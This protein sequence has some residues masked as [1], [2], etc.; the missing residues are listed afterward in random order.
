MASWMRTWL[1]ATWF[2]KSQYASP[3]PKRLSWILL[4]FIHLLL[5]IST[6]T[7]LFYHQLLASLPSCCTKAYIYPIFRHIPNIFYKYV[8]ISL[9]IYWLR[10]I[11]NYFYVLLIK[12]GTFEVTSQY[13]AY[14]ISISSIVFENDK[15]IGLF[16]GCFGHFNMSHH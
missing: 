8:Y 12:I 7:Y 13:F 5:I 3:M 14:F 1:W 10:R 9:L 16:G 2:T 6:Y 15:K 4:F 11:N